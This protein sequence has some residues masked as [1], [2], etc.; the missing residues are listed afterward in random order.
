MKKG[1]LKMF[2]N[3]YVSIQDIKEYKKGEVSLGLSSLEKAPFESNKAM[4]FISLNTEGFTMIWIIQV[5]IL[6][7]VTQQQRS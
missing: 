1:D 5:T 4:S 2:P 3:Q 7:A 6:S